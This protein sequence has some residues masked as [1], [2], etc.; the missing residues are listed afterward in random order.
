MARIDGTGRLVQWAPAAPVIADPAPAFDGRG[1]VPE[2]PA[3]DE[4][5]RVARNDRP[6]K[7]VR[8]ADREE[9]TF[10]LILVDYSTSDV[11]C[12]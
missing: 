9:G 10:A 8:F 12:D 11:A 3:P 2:V 5:A 4:D 7:R 1:V 6:A